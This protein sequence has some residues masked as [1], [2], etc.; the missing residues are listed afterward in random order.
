MTAAALATGASTAFAL[1]TIDGVVQNAT[2]A[3]ASA[4]IRERHHCRR[5]P[6]HVPGR[7]NGDGERHLP[8]HRQCFRERCN[9]NGQRNRRGNAAVTNSGTMTVTANAAAVAGNAAA[10][11]NATAT[12]RATGVLQIGVGVAPSLSV[13]NDGT[14]NVGA[15]ATATAEEIANADAFAMG[16]EQ[17]NFVAGPVT[18]NNN[19]ALNVNAAATATATG[20]VPLTS[21]ATATATGYRAVTFGVADVVAVNSGT[22]A[23]S[24]TAVAGS[25][26]NANAL[27]M[28]ITAVTAGA[29]SVSNVGSMTV[30]AS[31]SGGTSTATATG[32]RVFHN[33]TT[34][35]T[36]SGSIAVDAIASSASATG[37][38]VTGTGALT[39]DNSGVLTV[40]ESSDGGDTF[41]RGLAMALEGSTGV[42]AVNLLGGGDIYGD[43]D[44]KAADVITVSDGE[45]S[46]DGIINPDLFAL[47]APIDATDLDNIAVLGEGTLTIADGG[48]L[49]VRDA[50]FSGPANQYAGPSYALVDVLNVNA[51]GTLAMEFTP[52]APGVQPVGSYSQIFANTANLNGTFEAR[53]TSANGLFD[54]MSFDNVI[55]ADVRVGGFDGANCVIG[56]ALT[57]TLLLELDCVEDA[58]NNIDL[59]VTR[60]LF[61]EI[62]TDNDNAA[63]VAAGLECIF[64]TDLTGGVADLLAE[65]FMI[66][67]VAE[68]NVALNQLSGSSYA[69]YLQSFW[70]LGAHFND[71]VDRATSCEVPA[72]AGSALEC[73]ASAPIHIWAQADYQ[74]RKVEGDIEAG[75]YRSK[76]TTFLVGSDIA[77]ANSAILG[78]SV[79]NARNSVTDRQFGDKIRGDGIQIGAYGVFDPGA[80]YAKAMVTH[81]WFRGDSERD[82]AV[83][84]FSGTSRRRAGRE[85]A[86]RRPA[87][88]RA[89]PDGRYFGHHTVPQPRL[90]QGEDEG[91]H[92]GRARGCQPSPRRRQP[93]PHLPDRR[94]EV[95]RPVWRRGSGSERRLPPSLRQQAVA[96]RGGVP[97]PDGHRLRV[98]DRLG[99]REAGHLPRRPERRRQV[100]PDRSADRLRR[101]VQQRRDEPCRQHPDRG[102]DRWSRGS[103]AAAAPAAG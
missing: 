97:L 98:R 81:T 89:V 49:F 22:I 59:D 21:V 66:D 17:I 62:P 46:F 78:V 60:V 10:V 33:G 57:G 43:I 94:R 16:V 55:D 20:D 11:D 5:R 82:I 27:G 1:A 35:I 93:Q 100:G 48:T 24:A 79:G 34:L 87:R 95:G 68:F 42:T 91:V 88:W 44:I 92:R 40:R 39:I 41:T 61:T 72:L 86:D 74:R 56:G 99:R 102:S 2:G 50:E 45:T 36:N 3:T 25:T 19:G 75:D 23:V 14:I 83:G 9:S 90:R 84:A 73:R 4:V 76:R 47:I 85:P 77:I 26:A 13:V 65:L 31:A 38:V 69:N 28:G 15:H 54:D 80:F 53:F 32:I 51:G 71:L 64:D 8:G 63:A 96:L 103:A 37:I 67:N 12:A 30:V 52:N 70:S 7:G 18:F 101:R 58:A 29:A 6:G